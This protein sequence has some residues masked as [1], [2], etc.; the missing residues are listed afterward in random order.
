MQI[1]SLTLKSNIIIINNASDI[2]KLCTKKE[3]KDN[4]AKIQDSSLLEEKID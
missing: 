3:K 4:K 1:N 2:I